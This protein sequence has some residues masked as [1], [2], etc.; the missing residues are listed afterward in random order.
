MMSIVSHLRRMINRDLVRACPSL[1]CPALFDIHLL[2][3]LECK[4]ILRKE[5]IDLL[6]SLPTSLGTQEEASISISVQRT[7]SGS[8]GH[9]MR[10]T[11]TNATAIM[12]PDNTHS[13]NFHPIF[14]NPIGPAKTVMNVI[15]HSPKAVAAPPICLYSSGAIS[16]Q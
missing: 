5:E 6:Q 2:H 4:G 8:K 11:H 16:E 12:L 7:S 13:Q 14:V 15:N 1:L 9:K 10:Y 3:V